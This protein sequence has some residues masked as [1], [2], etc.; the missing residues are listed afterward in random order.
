MKYKKNNMFHG[1]NMCFKKV[2]LE[3]CILKINLEI[4]LFNYLSQFKKD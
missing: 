2:Y 3:Q 1:A 4:D